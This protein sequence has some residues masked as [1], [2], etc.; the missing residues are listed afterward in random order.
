MQN[1]IAKSNIERFNRLISTT[2]DSG[3]LATLQG[4]LASE[5]AKQTAV[6]VKR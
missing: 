3:Q 4:L 1:Y 5:R 2:T 6:P